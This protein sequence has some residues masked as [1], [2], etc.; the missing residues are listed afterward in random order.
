V[1]QKNVAQQRL[2]IGALSVYA[3]ACL[4]FVVLAPTTHGRANI[5]HD[6]VSYSQR[7]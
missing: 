4:F 3:S 7:G 2:A 5:T 1:P 6:A